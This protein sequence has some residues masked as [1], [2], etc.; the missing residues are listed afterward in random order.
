MLAR[1]PLPGRQHNGQHNGRMILHER[2]WRISIA[3]FLCFCVVT[4][5]LH[6]VLRGFGWW[7]AMMSMVLVVLGSA[8][9]VRSVSRRPGLPT[10]VASLVL[11]MTITAFFAPRSAFLFVIPSFE[12]L[13]I[14]GDL[15]QAG[16]LSV[17]RQSVPAEVAFGLAFVLCL[18]AGALA[19][20]ADFVAVTWRR[21][22]LAA[23]PLAVILA[24]PTFIGIQLADVFIFTLAAIAWLVLL[25][26][27][28]PF[29]QT[30]RSLAI[31][32]VA[33]VTALV[34]PLVLPQVNETQ[35]SG[36][37]FG[38]YLASVNPVLKLGEELR[39]ELPRTILTYSTSSG[40][41]TYLRLVSLR[42]FLPQTWQP[43]ARTIERNNSPSQVAA[44]PGL[45]SEVA[46]EKE[47][48]WIDVDNLG[49]PWLPVPYPATSVSGLR[50]D[51]F[52]DAQDLTF[53][54]PNVIARGEA[55]RVSS[56]MVSPTPTQLDAAR[57]TMPVA[58]DK[59][60]QLPTDLPAII[61]D[62]AS[63][64]TAAAKSDYA[65]AVSLQEYF[66]DG[67]FTYSETAPVDNGYDS[68]GMTAIA[69]FLVA[70]SGYCI[71]FASAMAIM[72]RTLGIPSRVAI[73]FLP[74]E[75][76]PITVQ[77]KATYRVTTHDVHS[78][79]ELYF[80]GIGWTRFEPT[81]G[82]G[83]AP[84][85]ADAATPGVPITPNT[86]PTPTATPTPTAA[87]SRSAAPVDPKNANASSATGSS[88]QGW[89][90]TALVVLGIVLLLL[91]P[92]FVRGGQRAVRL[93]RFARGHPA[94]TTGWKELLQSVRDLGVEISSTATPRE[95]AAA[96]TK[97][98]HLGES[99]RVTLAAILGLVERQS[100]AGEAPSFVGL[101]PKPVTSRSAR[102][103][104]AG[105]AN[106]V[107][108]ILDSVRSASGWRARVVAVIAPRSIWSQLAVSRAG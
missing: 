53:K 34:V 2:S 90:L 101:R 35:A 104:D 57:G 13:G 80:D 105:W 97:A 55:Y 11:M 107:I 46:T 84:S 59:Y 87:P 102:E 93:R 58:E 83:F 48:T 23:V 86:A 31:G 43:D 88:S 18:G 70:Q 72:A 16:A 47:T 45:S 73:G 4:A 61:R 62:I 9:L 99:D 68:N 60:L 41:P 74:G 26:A 89:L 33:V 37:G 32:T 25:R 54:S 20:V 94:A 92:A 81:P 100:F 50:G 8:A 15:G 77:G 69:Q 3:L 71:H 10:V 63:E 36:D 49:S 7:F 42:N 38:G 75:K 19:V 98:A 64:V 82:R 108:T 30:G 78:W 56:L 85:Y 40:D 66:R 65:R 5:A 17:A 96:I 52:W 14:F 79:P 6:T 27:G 12:T 1:K 95:A 29:S 103:S 28:Q 22:A 44:A 91:V 39:R 106:R 76:Q 21:P 67:S 51:W 24:I